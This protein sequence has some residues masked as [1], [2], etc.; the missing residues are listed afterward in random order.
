[1]SETLLSDDSGEPG[2]DG[3]AVGKYRLMAKLG[4]GGMADVYLAL[5]RGAL[6]VNKLV[7]I[8]QLREGLATNPD[9]VTMFLDEA[10]LAVRLN[11]ANVVHTY[12][13]GERAGQCFLV[14]EYLEG[15]AVDELLL[16]AR[17]VGVGVPAPVW[18]RVV[19]DA[20]AGLHYAHE[21]CDY[22]GTP[23]QI[24]HRDV[25]PQNLFV[26]Y[27]GITKVVDFGI[28]KARL[29]ATVTDAGEL[30]GKVCYMAPEHVL[31]RSSD[32]RAD[33]FAMGVVLWELLAGGRRLFKG[34]AGQALQNVLHA[35]IPR[36]SSVAPGVPKA[37]EAIVA[38]ALERDP[39]V[40]YQSAEEMRMALDAFLM[41]DDG[42]VGNEGVGR[43]IVR[44][45]GDLREKVRR[46]V[47]ALMAK[48][49]GGGP[50]AAGQEPRSLAGALG[51]EGSFTGS[52]PLDLTRLSG[53]RVGAGLPLLMT[54]SG[55]VLAAA[56][57]PAPAPMAPPSP[58]GG[59]VAAPPRGGRWAGYALVGLAALVVGGGLS[60]ALR[61]RQVAGA[62]TPGPAVAVAGATPG[63]AVA[64]TGATPGPAVA[65]ATPGPAAQAGAGVVRLESAPPGAEVES[66]GLPVGRTPAAVRLAPGEH[67]VTFR[68][69]GYEVESVVVRVEAGGESLRAVTLR[70]AGAEPV[71]AARAPATPRGKRRGA[72]ARP[73]P[74]PPSAPA[75]PAISAPAEPVRPKVKLVDEG[76]RSLRL[77]E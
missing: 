7:V 6:G 58:G 20:L 14:M 54:P 32:R 39:D 59:P 35:P 17:A 36:L 13:A 38:R 73:E 28:A 16:R 26:T 9:F 11:H 64:V 15:L 23:L 25:S 4:Q 37:L 70:P 44:V 61:A 10:R 27:D 51:R 30:K 63:P 43:T 48:A 12:E 68:K 5:S 42:F 50:G 46:R 19:S 34:D 47:Q 66:G 53:A 60:A 24:T 76:K 62:A 1:M 41:S 22:D 40:R 2:G 77:D 69:E 29:N 31:G 45:A 55:T 56:P 3:A 52:L 65:G 57:T 67:A 74:A 8:K 71:A 75:A 72:S 49:G 21:L 18:A 33:V